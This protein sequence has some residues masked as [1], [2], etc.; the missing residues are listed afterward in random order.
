M[1]EVEA[2]VEVEVDQMVAVVS[3]ITNTPMDKPTSVMEISVTRPT[4]RVIIL[5][6][7]VGTF[8]TIAILGGFLWMGGGRAYSQTFGMVGEVVFINQC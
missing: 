5:G 6:Q 8:K 1:E 7:W 3:G 4:F 2:M